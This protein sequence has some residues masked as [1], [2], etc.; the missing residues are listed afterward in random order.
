MAHALVECESPGPHCPYERAD[1]ELSLSPV[2][3]GVSVV[4]LVDRA[5][6]IPPHS[7]ICLVPSTGPSVA[8]VTE[9]P[10]PYS[11]V[12]RS[13]EIDRRWAARALP[14]LDERA[15]R[16]VV[17][18][19]ISRRRREPRPVHLLR[20]VNGDAVGVVGVDEEVDRA[21]AR[22]LLA[23]WDQGRG[24]AKRRIEREVW[25]D[26]RSHGR[27]FDRFISPTLGEP[28]TRPSRQSDRLEEITRQVR[29][30]G[31]LPIG[32]TP[33]PWERQLAGLRICWSSAEW[34]SSG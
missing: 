21:L 11:A 31:E 14:A 18:G 2:A 6:K 7:L 4:R 29:G 25:D 12:G 27:R 30:L 24:T 13:A 9:P 5:E 1:V 3:V 34:C 23:E 15:H 19:G 10:A 33:Q 32:G 17:S 22:R 20:L 26:G 8:A 28:T 16:A